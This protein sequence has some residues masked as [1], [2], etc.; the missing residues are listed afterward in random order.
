MTSSAAHLKG[1]PYVERLLCNSPG[2]SYV[3]QTEW[4]SSSQETPYNFSQWV[5]LRST[6][7]LP[8]SVTAVGGVF[9][10]C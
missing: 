9:N 5:I 8:C 1:L 2:C 6:G 3:G 10:M 7:Q 4:F